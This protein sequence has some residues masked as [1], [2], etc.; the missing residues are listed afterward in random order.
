MSHSMSRKTRRQALQMTMGTLAVGLMVPPSARAAWPKDAFE[1]KTV[2]EALEALFKVSS[3]TRSDSITL[4][5]PELAENG[6]VVPVTVQTTLTN[7]ESVVL[8]ADGNPRSLVAM[9]TL[10]PRTQPPLTV[11]MKLAQSQNVV[12]VVKAGGSFY[13]ASQMIKV[14]IGGCGG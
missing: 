2:R 14:S 13:S 8:L 9:M 7:V 1:A 12:A 11:R 5:A 6:T 10:S 4:L 3:P